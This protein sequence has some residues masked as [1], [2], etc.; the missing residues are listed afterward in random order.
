MSPISGSIDSS[1]S[2]AD[3]CQAVYAPFGPAFGQLVK[4]RLARDQF[5]AMMGCIPPL[6]R[7]LPRRDDVPRD[8]FLVVEAGNRGST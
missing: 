3:Q 6:L 5:M 8:P 4:H 7:P 2:P 1:G